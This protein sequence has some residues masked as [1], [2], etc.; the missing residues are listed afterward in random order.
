MLLCG[1]DGAFKQYFLG[2]SFIEPACIDSCLA[3]DNGFCLSTEDGL[4]LLR[5]DEDSDER[6]P[7]R[8][9]GDK[10]EVSKSF[11]GK[12]KER[13]ICMVAT[14]QEDRLYV[15]TNQ[16]QL[17][18]AKWDLRS[19]SLETEPN[20]SPVMCEFHRKEVTGLDVCIRKQLI[21]TCSKDKTVR[22]WN[23]ARRK[24]EVKVFESGDECLAIAFHPS[25]FHLLVAGQDKIQI[26]NI[27][28]NEIKV[29]QGGNGTLS[30]KA[31][32]E[33]RFSN[34]GHLF[35]CAAG[36]S[37]KEIH[38]YNFYTGEC[39]KSMQY[40]GHTAKV[41]SIAWFENDMGFAS[42]AADGNIYF[43]DLY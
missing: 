11:D 13:A 8:M 30:I 42:T 6:Q 14:K 18:E 2:S 24:L 7:L 16:G 28:S 23:Y 29:P 5:I 20:F 15:V 39:H 36:Q 21:A 31:C 38:I 40:T 9:V 4:V 12:N 19:D 10:I 25:G 26:C 17:M 35:A 3:L 32:S 1:N 33:I 27:L 22:V 43:Y 34:G 37:T 41:R